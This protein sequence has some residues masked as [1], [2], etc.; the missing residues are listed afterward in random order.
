MHRVRKTQ[1]GRVSLSYHFISKTIP[2]KFKVAHLV[3]S[4]APMDLTSQ[5]YLSPGKGK[6]NVIDSYSFK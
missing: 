2:N 5:S 6:R 1:I 4:Q 3:Q